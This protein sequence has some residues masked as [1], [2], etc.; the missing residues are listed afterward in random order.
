MSQGKSQAMPNST[1]HARKPVIGLVT[2]YL[3]GLPHDRHAAGNKYIRAISDSMDAT[4]ILLPA[5]GEDS[6]IDAWLDLLD[7]LLL[8]G[9][10]S[11]VEPRH[12]QGKDSNPE[13]LHDPQRDSTSLPLV[14]AAI[15]R[16]IPLLG[17]CRGFQEI[18]VALGGSL[19]Q[20]VHLVD[21]KID[22]R[23]NKN[24]SLEQQYA[25]A[26]RVQL[27]GDGLLSKA[28]GEDSIMVNSLHG[29]GIEQLAEPLIAEASAPDGLVEAFRHSD[30][31]RFVY[32]VQWHPEWK[33]ADNPFYQAIFTLF[34]SACLSQ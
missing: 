4:P 3:Q 8:T 22:H 13:T 17:I 14:K 11:N 12:Y 29:Q 28:L 33:T 10:Y 18:N 27:A 23:E 30:S 32:G 1:E 9:A 31:E 24:A 21:Q 6:P 26:H 7:G 19:H 25:A 15:T 20:H 5:L 16:G 34:K 2:D